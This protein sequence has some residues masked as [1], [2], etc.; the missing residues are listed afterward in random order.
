MGSVVLPHVYEFTGSL[1]SLKCSFEHC[2]RTSD[3]CH[4]GPVGGLTRIHI[5]NL[6]SRLFAY[7]FLSSLF[8]GCH[9]GIDYFFVATFAEIRHAFYDSF[10]INGVFEKVHKGNAFA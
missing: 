10:H 6:H 7:G 5:Q 4:D 8:D 9:D 3:K 2:L 1:H